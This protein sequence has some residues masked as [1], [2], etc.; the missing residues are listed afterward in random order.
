MSALQTL[1]QAPPVEPV[2]AANTAQTGRKPMHVGSFDGSKK[3]EGS[4]SAL[5]IAPEAPQQPVSATP[6]QPLIHSYNHRLARMGEV[7]QALKMVLDRAEELE[8]P[9]STIGYTER[10]YKSAKAHLAK[11]VS[12]MAAEN[13]E[14]FIPAKP[15]QPAPATQPD[16]A[17]YQPAT[18]APVV[19]PAPPPVVSDGM[20]ARLEA[21]FRGD[22]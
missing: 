9:E 17:G 18:L 13:P 1:K 20:A 6:V 7:V 8:L 21:K 19:Q 22:A 3:Q 10:C 15:V 16:V 14:M 11:L 12:E 2:E 4:S 5:Q